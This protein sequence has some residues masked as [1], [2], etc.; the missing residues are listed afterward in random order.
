VSIFIECDRECLAGRVQAISRNRLRAAR[1]LIP[2]DLLRNTRLGRQP[3]LGA[4]LHRVSSGQGQRGQ[5]Q[6]STSP[7]TMDTRTAEAYVDIRFV[8]T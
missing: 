4:A 3:R 5:L 8:Y 2:G 1:F 7:K 6:Y